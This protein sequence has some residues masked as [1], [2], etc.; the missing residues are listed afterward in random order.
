M[1][2]CSMFL[3]VLLLGSI[4]SHS[5]LEAYVSLKGYHNEFQGKIGCNVDIDSSART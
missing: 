2:T 1:F 5:M 3:S 4:E